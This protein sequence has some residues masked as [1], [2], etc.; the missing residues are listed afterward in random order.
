MLEFRNIKKTF[1]NGTVKYEA[2]K[3]LNLTIQEGE[4][5]SLLGPSGCGKTT[6]LRMI[7][8]L[9][10]PSSGE[11]FFKGQRIDSWP[12]QKRPFHMVFQKYA[13][14]PHLSVAENIAF[15]LKLQK[16]SRDE[17]QSRVTDVLKL[18]HMQGFE[19]RSPETLSGGQA[20]RIA[21]AR[22]L[23]NRPQILLLDEPLSALDQKL[24]EHM[25]TELKDLQR[26]L[27]LTFIY[28]THDQ[29]E[30]LA[31]SDRVAV[32]NEG[33]IEQV[34][35]P[36]QLYREP[37]SLFAAHFIGPMTSFK[38]QWQG[39]EG[40]FSVVRFKDQNLKC[41]AVESLKH[42]SLKLMIRPENLRLSLEANSPKLSSNRISG[43]ISQTVF[44]GSQNEIAVAL[45]S[46]E[47]VRV[48]TASHCKITVGETVSL[49][50]DPQD[51]FLFEG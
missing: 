41:R 45:A 38:V 24:R 28:V 14:F 16:L 8:G 40:P 48:L 42:N 10:F 33:K 11:I 18:V 19:A 26:Q 9:E 3:D 13:L 2:V 21:I 51:A 31:L 17:I 39:K 15:G 7:A 29:E 35:S 30:A 34:N 37:Q 32:M 5:F 47:H 1:F 12:A 50:F 25:Q 22:A 46:G 4:F 49:E 36:Q 44:R 43:V 27:G 23:V 6:L 20:Q